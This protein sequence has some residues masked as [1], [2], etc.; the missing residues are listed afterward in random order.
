M[1]ITTADATLIRE[2]ILLARRNHDSDIEIA[3]DAQV[4]RG[5]KLRERAY[6]RTWV[7]CVQGKVFFPPRKSYTRRNPRMH[8]ERQTAEM[9]EE[10]LNL[11]ERYGEVKNYPRNLRWV[12]R[13]LRE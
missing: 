11:F 2:G 13:T 3:F 5:S 7:R 10:F 12:G 4:P 1:T 8:G 6:R 9:I